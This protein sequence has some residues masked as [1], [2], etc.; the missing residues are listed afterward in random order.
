MKSL[1]KSLDNEFNKNPVSK[2]VFVRAKEMSTYTDTMYDLYFAKDYEKIFSE[3]CKSSTLL[4]AEASGDGLSLKLS[5]DIVLKE[6]KSYEEFIKKLSKVRGLSEVV[7][8]AA[9]NDVDY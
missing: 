4:N 8:V 1:I 5:F 6:E 7:A 9:K 3:N 2:E